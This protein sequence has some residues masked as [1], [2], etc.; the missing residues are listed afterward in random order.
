MEIFNVGIMEVG[1][2]L[3]IVLMVFNPKDISK[4]VKAVLKTIR[5]VKQ[6]E[7]WEE[8]SSTFK[9]IKA[10]PNKLKE[11]VENELDD[12][13]EAVSE[14]PRV[15]NKQVPPKITQLTQEVE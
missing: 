6:S 2:I 14:E 8:F 1:F 11:M 5:S 12:E 4:N 10:Y 15:R 3:V 7:L 9:E 13:P